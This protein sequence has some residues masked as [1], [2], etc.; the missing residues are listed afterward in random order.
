MYLLLKKKLLTTH[1]TYHILHMHVH[2]DDIAKKCRKYSIVI[3]AITLVD[4]SLEHV[5][6]DV[7]KFNVCILL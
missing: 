3:L 7:I 6:I 1:I 5:V 4:F 2:Y